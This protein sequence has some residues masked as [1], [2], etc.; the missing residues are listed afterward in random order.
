MPRYVVTDRSHSGHCC[1]DA[2]VV[3]TESPTMLNGKPFAPRGV[4]E[5]NSV[6]ECIDYDNAELIAAALNAPH[7]KEVP[8]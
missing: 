2:S 4:Q 7:D 5:Y 8:T 6:C 3:D 1:F